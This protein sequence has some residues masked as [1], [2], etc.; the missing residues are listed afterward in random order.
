[1][2]NTSQLCDETEVDGFFLFRINRTNLFTSIL[3]VFIAKFF[4]PTPFSTAFTPPSPISQRAFSISN[5]QIL[6]QEFYFAD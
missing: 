3:H 4:K 5:S 6:R 1:M 2:T